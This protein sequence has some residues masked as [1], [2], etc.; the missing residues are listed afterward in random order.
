[1]MSVFYAAIAPRPSIT[2]WLL[3]KPQRDVINTSLAVRVVAPGTMFLA[4][5]LMH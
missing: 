2:D 1:M 5:T 4:V 3:F